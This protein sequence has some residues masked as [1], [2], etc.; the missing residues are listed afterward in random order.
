M[1]DQLPLSP[2]THRAGTNNGC[3]AERRNSGNDVHL[4][5]DLLTSFIDKD[6]TTY[7][8]SDHPYLC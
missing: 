7:P 8:Y 3:P 6:A 4:Q 2:E 5:V 1:G